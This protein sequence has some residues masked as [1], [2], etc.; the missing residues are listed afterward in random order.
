MAQDNAG[1]N[2]M[3]LAF[4]LR[5]DKRLD[6]GGRLAAAPLAACTYEEHIKQSLHTLLLT[7]RR[8]RI[9]RRDF[10][11]RLGDY[12]FENI[13]TTTAALARNEIINTIENYEP[14]VE[15][16]DVTVRAG[17]VPGV[18]SIEIMYR[19]ASTGA[20]DRLALSIGR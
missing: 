10:G 19:I 12:L 2:K 18:I 8:Q 20:A 14:R 3:G 11:N 17:Q 7:S 15:I 5:L 4:P 16:D 6:S 9:M 1:E 13:G